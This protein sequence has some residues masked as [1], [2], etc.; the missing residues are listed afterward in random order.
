MIQV[1]RGLLRSLVKPT[2]NWK[3]RIANYLFWIPMVVREAMVESEGY[4]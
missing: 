1:N 2:G 4:L 3:F